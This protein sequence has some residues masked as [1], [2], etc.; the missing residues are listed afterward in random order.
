MARGR[1]GEGGARRGRGGAT[2]GGGHEEGSASCEGRQ[3]QASPQIPCQ[4]WGSPSWVAF[5]DA[6]TPVSYKA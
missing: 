1:D 5:D 6:C 4:H 3:G 2:S